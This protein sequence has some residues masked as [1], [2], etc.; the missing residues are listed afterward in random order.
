MKVGDHIE[1]WLKARQLS[2]AS[3]SRRCGLKPWRIHAMKRNRN[4]RMDAIV[5]LM[6]GLKLSDQELADFLE[7]FR[8]AKPEF[9]NR[10]VGQMYLFP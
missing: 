8:K 1:Q 6:A 10:N 7:D 3:A 2:V 4:C 5:G 9:D